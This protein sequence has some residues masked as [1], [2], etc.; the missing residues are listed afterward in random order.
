MSKN[1]NKGSFKDNLIARSEEATKVRKI[2]SVIILAILLLIIVGGV[3]GYLY[4]KSALEPVDPNNGEEIIVEIPLG[5]SSSNIA[6]I[7]EESGVI[8]NATIFQL[9]IKLNNYSDFQAG[10]YT[11]TQSMSLDEIA[12]NIQEGKVLQEPIYRVTIPEG[13][14]IEQMAD[15]YAEKL[16]FTKEEFLEVVN[17][18]DY[19]NELIKRYSV[20]TE[21]ILQE[22]ILVPL[23]G[24]LFAATYD[25][26]EEEPTVESV[27]EQMLSQTELIVSNYLAAIEERGL[28]IHEAVTLSSLVEKEAS[29]EEQRKQIAGVFYN[30]LEEGM[31]LQTDPTVA[32]AIGEH[33]Q[34]T[35][36]E[37]LEEDS[38][39]NTYMIEGLPI[40]PISN[41]SASS[42]DAVVN[43][44]DSD[45]LYFLHD[46]Q[47]NIHYAETNEEH[48]QNRAEY[49]N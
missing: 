20:L 9:Y 29:N 39:Y 24:Y 21:D 27:I 37:H 19:I 3:S 23:E 40:G 7:L 32:Y 48:N 33:L 11:L 22:D 1:N 26:Y 12:E 5:S 4:I 14:T 10:N 31:K 41:F 46:A 17:N 44:M 35:L 36:Y 8:K 13:L 16:P 49:L 2:A 38:P 43:P 25:F 30:R 45:Y 6:S 18:E 42:L 47:G 34:T 15:I 28:T